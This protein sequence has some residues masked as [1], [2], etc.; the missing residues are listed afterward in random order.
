MTAAAPTLVPAPP[1]IPPSPHNHNQHQANAHGGN[2]SNKLVMSPDSSSVVDDKDK[3][4][5]HPFIQARTSPTA[6]VVSCSAGPG[7]GSQLTWTS[8][9]GAG[10]GPIMPAGIAYPVMGLPQDPTG[11][12]TA[13]MIYGVPIAT[14]DHQVVSPGVNSVLSLPTSTPNVVQQQPPTAISISP[15]IQQSNP[16]VV[17]STTISPL[18]PATGSVQPQQHNV[19]TS[20][21]SLLSST[22]VPQQQQHPTKEII[23]CKSCTLFPPNPNAPPPTTREKPPGCRTAFVGGLPENITENLVREI[24]ERCG[25]ITTIR[26]SKKNFCHIRFEMEQFVELALYLSGYR[27]RIGSNS[28]SANIGRLHVDYAQARDDLYEWECRQRQLLREQRHR[29]RL[30]QERLQPPSPPPAVHYSDHEAANV[31]ERI[32]GTSPSFTSPQQ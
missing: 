30:E 28:E 27:I 12:A 14:Q 9:A 29:E 1:P 4:P 15:V 8:P 20:S 16:G 3:C 24:F 2:P 17:G 7:Q 11:A 26:M 5:A 18:G 19:P 13:G 6:V 21:A 22:G 31:S 23:H 10:G 25:E 32:K